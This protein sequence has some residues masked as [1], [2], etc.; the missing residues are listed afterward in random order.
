MPLA[1]TWGIEVE[2]TRLFRTT[3]G[4]RRADRRRRRHGRGR[5]QGPRG[6]DAGAERRGQPRLHLRR[7][8]RADELDPAT[9]HCSQ[10]PLEP[11]LLEA[12]IR[13][14]DALGIY[15][16]HRRDILFNV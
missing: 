15:M 11:G 6:G 4:A 3:G 1:Y 10:A 9:P 7:A 12:L 5:P 2:L 13:I 16:G 8:T 14:P